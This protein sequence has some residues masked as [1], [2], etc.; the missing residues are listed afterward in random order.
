MSQGAC[1]KYTRKSLR[2]TKE[3]RVKEGYERIK[4]LAKVG[5]HKEALELNT[6]I[7]K[8]PKYSV[9][10]IVLSIQK[11]DHLVEHLKANIADLNID[12]LCNLR[13]EGKYEEARYLIKEYNKLFMTRTK[14]MKVKNE[15]NK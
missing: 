3:E 1:G 11:T 7:K 12:I 6:V 9:A 15:S 14:K 13:K 2:V 5:R 8:W 4:L 10:F